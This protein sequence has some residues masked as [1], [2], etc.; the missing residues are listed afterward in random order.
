MKLSPEQTTLQARGLTAA[1]LKAALV[2]LY[3]LGCI[4]TVKGQQRVVVGHWAAHSIAYLQ[5]RLIH[6][7]HARASWVDVFKNLIVRNTP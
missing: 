6:R 1:A 2:E 3:P 5:A 7:V 4:V